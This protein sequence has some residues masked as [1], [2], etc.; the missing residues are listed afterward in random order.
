MTTYKYQ[1]KTTK[2]YISAEEYN[3]LRDEKFEQLKGG[4]CDFELWVENN[5]SPWQVM[6]WCTESGPDFAESLM[7]SRWHDSIWRTA[8]NELLKDWKVI[9]IFNKKV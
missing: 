3:K 2:E 5:I 1:N 6:D 7:Y 8:E 9:K 4:R